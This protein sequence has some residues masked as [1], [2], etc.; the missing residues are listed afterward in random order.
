[1]IDNR[2]EVLLHHFGVIGNSFIYYSAAN[3]IYRRHF[4]DLCPKLQIKMT[5]IACCLGWDN[6][7]NRNL[8]SVDANL[9][10]LRPNKIYQPC[11]SPSLRNFLCLEYECIMLI[12]IYHPRSQ[13]PVRLH[14]P[15]GEG[16]WISAE[17][18]K[19]K[20]TPE[21]QHSDNR[22][23]PIFKHLLYPGF[24]QGLKSCQVQLGHLPKPRDSCRIK[25]VFSIQ[26]F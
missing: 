23:F 7:K 25:R 19:R 14:L 4:T 18:V 12:D 8:S 3:F 16:H 20:T 10:I 24:R 17:R 11:R 13:P 21:T 1:M 15:R 6:T 5:I 22:E 26:T 2:K 9:D